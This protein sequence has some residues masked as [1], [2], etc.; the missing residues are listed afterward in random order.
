MVYK[1]GDRVRLAKG[2]KPTYALEF[3][4]VTKILQVNQDRFDTHRAWYAVDRFPKH[5]LRNIY[6]EEELE[7]ADSEEEYLQLL[8]G[9][10]DD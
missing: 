1:I 8:N 10:K 2:F 3:I 7:K 9:E 6:W 4:G 5:S